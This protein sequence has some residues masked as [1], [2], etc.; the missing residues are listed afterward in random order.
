VAQNTIVDDVIADTAARVV[1]L[2][3]KTE[4]LAR[5]ALTASMTSISVRP[6]TVSA[7]TLRGAPPVYQGNIDIST[8]VKQSYNEALNA[9]RPEFMDGMAYY[10]A[11]WF[12]ECVTTTTDNWI[13]NTILTGGTG[14]PEGIENMIWERARSKEV[15]EAHRIEQEA[16]STFAS[17]GFSMPPGALVMAAYRAQENAAEKS[18]TIARETAIKHIDI[19]IENIRF[20]VG[21]GVKLRIAV[22]SAIN[23]FL[24]AWMLPESLAI[25]KAKAITESKSSRANSAAAYYNAMISEADLNL[26]AQAIN[27]GSWDSATKS[28]VDSTVA[29]TNLRAG[30]NKDLAKTYGDAAAAAA[31]GI[32]SVAG[33]TLTGFASS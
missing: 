30:V 31:S 20:A 26:K 14:L 23:D 25:E 27:S 3:D 7:P 6:F 32:V 28:Q 22:L 21:E 2:T 17:R 29:L 10:L 11:R 19:I 8:E 12:P 18:S 15:M 13:C 33:S 1:E 4:Q 5:N 9:M 24:K 16:V